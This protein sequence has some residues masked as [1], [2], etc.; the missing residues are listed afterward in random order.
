MF[1]TKS[2]ATVLA[3]EPMTG[4]YAH[5]GMVRHISDDFGSSTALCGKPLQYTIPMSNMDIATC[6]RC[7]KSAG[8][9]HCHTLDICVCRLYRAHTE[10]THTMTRLS[11]AV[12]VY[13][14]IEGSKSWE[15]MLQD[16]HPKQRCTH[17]VAA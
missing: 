10:D 5:H 17:A 2:G 1:T 15:V 8:H 7:R 14:C 9:H 12:P 6:K 3:N 4:G 13:A 11:T 16:A